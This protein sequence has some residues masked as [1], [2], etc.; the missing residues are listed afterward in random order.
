MRIWRRLTAA[1]AALLALGG[2]AAAFAAGG[3]GGCVARVPYR[4]RP[5]QDADALLLYEH[6]GPAEPRHLIPRSFYRDGEVIGHVA[7]PGRFAVIYMGWGSFTDLAG[8]AVN[9]AALYLSARGVMQGVSNPV[10]RG[11]RMTARFGPDEPVT[12]EDFAL[13]LSRLFDAPAPTPGVPQHGP[14]S[15]QNMLRMGF[16]A[17]RQAGLVAPTEGGMALR[18]LQDFALTDPANAPALLWLLQNG[19]LPVEAERLRP[20]DPATRADAALF[21][22]AIARFDAAHTP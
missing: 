17:M 3:T 19:L 9:R 7:A 20:N 8:E 1:A 22:Y 11:G 2:S 4:P 5:D 21:L 6:R 16:E 18:E 12:K 14:L 10:L 13:W 15:R